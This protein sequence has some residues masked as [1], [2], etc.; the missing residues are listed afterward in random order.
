MKGD[1][2]ALVFKIRIANSDDPDYVEI[3]VTPPWLNYYDLLKA[4]CEKLNISPRNVERIRKMPDTKLCN[5]SD[6]GRLTN[7]QSLEIVL[8]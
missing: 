3:E 2:D 8:K 1:T 6:V 5:D 4:C 7:Y